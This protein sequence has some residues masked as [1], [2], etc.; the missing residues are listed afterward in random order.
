MSTIEYTRAGLPHHPTQSD[1]S[2]N[3]DDDDDDSDK[4]GSVRAYDLNQ[5]RRYLLTSNAEQRAERRRQQD[6]LREELVNEVFVF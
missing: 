6:L 5:L 2:A 1:I 4:Q 3:D